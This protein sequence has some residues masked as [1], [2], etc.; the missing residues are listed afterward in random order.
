MAMGQ[1]SS[2]TPPPYI[3]PRCAPR[4]TTILAP[5]LQSNG[6]V[7]PA[8]PTFPDTFQVRVEANILEMNKTIVGEEFHDMNKRAA[9]RTITNNS[10]NYMILDYYNGQLFYDVNGV[11]YATD[12]KYDDNQLLFGMQMT[13]AGI[14]HFYST[15]QAL[16][17]AKANGMMYMGRQEIRG[18]LCAWWRS[19]MYWDILASNFTLDFFFTAQDS[20]FTWVG[21][22]NENVVPIRAEIHG[23]QYI[24]Q[25]DGSNSKN[26]HHIYE[27]FDFRN[28]I[29]APDDKFWPPQGVMCSGRRDPK[30]VPQLTSQ[31]SYRL[32]IVDSVNAA[33]SRADIYYDFSYQLVRFDYRPSSAGYPYYTT[34]PVT[35]IHDYS[36]GF[37]Y[38]IDKTQGNC[39]VRP[40]QNA[41][42]YASVTQRPDTQ[43]YIHMK[44][45]SQLLYLDNTT[46]SYEGQR[47]VRGMLCDVYI[48]KRT[49]FTLPNISINFTST[50]EFYFWSDSPINLTT[51]VQLVITT[52]DIV[53]YRETYNIYN[54][55]PED[56]TYNRFDVTICYDDNSQK[57]FTMEWPGS[58]G[59]SIALFQNQFVRAVTQT[60]SRLTHVQPIRVQ[61]P[62]FNFDS[63]KIYF[64]ATLVDAPSPLGTVDYQSS[65]IPLDKVWTT[66]KNSV[67]IGDFQFSLPING[68]HVQFTAGS[69]KVHEKKNTKT[70]CINDPQKSSGY[71]VGSIFG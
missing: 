59:S 37:A 12:L 24:P 53:G 70:P 7:L 31:Y 63:A 67:L 9:L 29:W 60:I 20:S 51:P 65:N 45:A 19:C 33:V 3:Y 28:A 48:S 15:A 5:Y 30:P 38:A 66:L 54:W 47:T 14:P 17:F 68:Q 13:G 39:S 2:T 4:N 71:N 8:V 44:A 32:E 35:Q 23:T 50:F 61:T 1:V 41:S 10:E 49:D 11:C 57:S 64:V 34:N 69:I 27:Y 16:Q 52:P 40:I 18:I 46:Y 26:F 43:F 21:P 25:V 58:G 62:T 55:V 36:T 6:T 42:F 56:P 22:D